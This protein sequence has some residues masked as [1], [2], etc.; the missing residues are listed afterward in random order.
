MVPNLLNI[1][2]AIRMVMSEKE[3]AAALIKHTN[4]CGAATGSSAADAYVRAREADSVSAFGAAVALNRSMSVET[5]RAIVSTRIDAVI[6]P[7]V[8]DDARAMLA[9]VSRQVGQRKP[10]PGK[11]A[12]RPPRYDA[13]LRLMPAHDLLSVDA[14]ELLAY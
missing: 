12:P 7:A 8:D 5:A 4:P 9:E 14:A 6:A 11:P 2:A 3:P 1:N 10:V 13:A